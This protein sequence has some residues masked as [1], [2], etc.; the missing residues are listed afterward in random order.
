MKKVILVFLFILQVFNVLSQ[1]DYRF[2]T[3]SPEGG[4]YFDGVRQIQQDTDGFVWILMDHDLYRF[5]GYQYK[6]YY[7]YFTNQEKSVEWLFLKLTVTSSGY[8]FVN[9]N[10]GLYNYDKASDTFEKVSDEVELIRIDNRDNIWIRKNRTWNVFDE[11]R[12]PFNINDS[13]LITP[14]Y[15]GKKIS[16]I[17]PI[18]C[19][20]NSDLYTFTNYSRIYRYNYEKKEFNL[21]FTMPE[22]DGHILDAKAYKSK[23][24]VLTDK[25]GLYKI[26]LSTFTIEDHF[27]F[28]KGGETRALHIDK[29]GHVWIGTIKGLYVIDP[30]EKTYHH[31]VHSKSDPFSLPNNSVWTINEDNQRNIW[32]GT[33]SGAIAYVNLDEK[34]PFDTYMP[35]EN[36]LSHAPV[37]AFAE[38]DTSLWIGTEGGGINRLNKKTEEFSY[39]TNDKSRNSLAFDNIKSIVVDKGQNLWI[40]LFNGGLDYYNAKSGQ[41][42]NFKQ[43]TGSNSILD[44][45]LRKIVLESDSGLW[46]AYQR[47]KVEISFYSFKTKQFYHH[48]PVGENTQYI[49]DMLRGR[50][51]QLWVLSNESLYLMDI[52]TKVMKK[53]NRPDSVF[54]NF[55]AF[56]LD[57]SGNLWIGTIKNGLVKYDVNADKF[58]LFDKILNYNVSS[59]YSINYDGEDNLWIGTDD[60]LFRY[61]ISNNTFF[62]YDKG[63]GTQG[64]VYYPLASMKSMGGKLYFGGTTG[65]TV[66]DPQEVSLNMHKPKVI[67]SDFYIDHQPSKLNFSSKDSIYEIVLSHNQTNFGFKFSSDNFLLPEKNHFKYRMRDYDNRWIEVDASSRTAMYSKVPAGTYYFEVLASNND[68]I[69][70][71]TPTVIKIIRKSAPWFSW[72]AYV[73]Y[74]LL[75]LG[76][77]SL[78]IRYY[79]E[80]KNLKMQLYLDN[81]EKDKKEE[82]HQS[83]LRFFTN[84]SHDFRTPL[85]LI[86]ASLDRLRE[87]GIKE[88]YY[89]ILNSN[90]QRLLNLVNELMDFRTIENEKM[91]LEIQ[92]LD[93][94]SFLEVVAAD[95]SDY[96]KQRDI[97]FKIVCDPALPTNLYV[98]KKIVEKI[99]M[100]LLNNAFKYSKE[101]SSISLETYSNIDSFK[102]QYENSYTVEGSQ[103]AE[104]AFSIVVRDTGVGIT[105][106]SISSVF[107]RFYKVNTVNADSHL[108]TGIGL[109]LVKSLVLLHKGTITI[110]S[111]RGKGT[112][113]VVCLPLDIKLYE[114]SDFLKEKIVVDDIAKEEDV[115]EKLDETILLCDKKKVLIVEDN[116]DLRSLIADSLSADYEIIE[117]SDGLVASKLIN[118]MEPDLIISDIMMPLKDGVTLCHE[119]KNDIN[120]SHIPFILLTAKTSLESKIEG[121]DSGA[122][123]YFEK[124]IDLNFLRISINNIFKYQQQL[125]EYYAKNYFAD[126]AELSQNE[127]DNKFLK[128]FIDI[129]EA[130]I[131][132][133]EMDVNYIATELSMSRSKLYTKIKTL[134]DKSIVEFILNYRLRKAARLIIEEDMTMREI[135]TQIGI[136]SQPYFTNAF[137]KEFGQ[138]PTAFAAKH[139]KKKK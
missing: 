114:E 92:P 105:K 42:Y 30:D 57:D 58:I 1:N 98:D 117:A 88:Y 56:C 121:V 139:K 8:F 93:L 110:L 82:I 20:N 70:S 45:S 3:L 13:I 113:M 94:N 34:K 53:I 44:N 85:S 64:R 106:E 59:I 12:N 21:C 112:D 62:E 68:G 100:N 14:L 41:F 103:V 22:D 29:R 48:S 133:S 80:K 138:T 43:T 39:Y 61:S 76:V 6:R 10:N 91:N 24:W 31:Y 32:I 47:K 126:S 96:A 95:F 26:D 51:N 124:P 97:D 37:S 120:T 104:K 74:A 132:Q 52:K 71:E 23:L 36:R 87:D 16:F 49:F 129:I 77:L 137:K 19:T 101:G 18:F 28:L 134:T 125:K 9:T 35:Y 5:D 119:I 122:D 72:P 40:A 108:G 25:Y 15:D 75:I 135:M 127:Q 107:E 111:E 67:I 17:G 11:N 84:I 131:D 4:F 118:S 2:R 115:N 38:D 7:T 130:N 81:I 99:V 109:A 65:F 63:D 123:M 69:W 78:I 27:D 60:G 102:S 54:L 50:E 116:E 83:Q 73:L 55:S 66:I 128:K 86:M 90:T 79:I 136:E 33:Y 46:I 89:R